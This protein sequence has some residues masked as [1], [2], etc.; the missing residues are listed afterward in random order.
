MIDIEDRIKKLPVWAQDHIADLERKVETQEEQLNED[1]HPKSSV[2]VGSRYSLDPLDMSYLPDGSRINFFLDPL[3]KRQQRWIEV[4]MAHGKLQ[5]HS[6]YN[7]V[8]RPQVSNGA[9]VDVERF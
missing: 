5:L 1:A 4:H 9:S 6:S 2:V 3:D 8:L 7:L